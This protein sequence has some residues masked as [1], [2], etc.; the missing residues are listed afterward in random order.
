[1]VR[2]LKVAHRRYWIRNVKQQPT[3]TGNVTGLSL[4]R[5]LLP[6][7][8]GR[9]QLAEQRL[10]VLLLVTPRLDIGHD[11]TALGLGPLQGPPAAGI[12]APRA[13]TLGPEVVPVLPESLTRGSGCKGQGAG[14]GNTFLASFT[15]VGFCHVV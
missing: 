4:G 10:K 15:C 13:R 14:S 11:A 3:L 12:A 7:H 6:G 9:P 1:M 5:L 8:D 2:R